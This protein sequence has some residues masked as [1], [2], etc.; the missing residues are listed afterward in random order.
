MKRKIIIPGI[1][2]LLA[3]GIFLYM[4]AN[5]G[6][7]IDVEKTSA[8]AVVTAA[9]L[10]QEYEA[11]EDKA[12]ETYASKVIQVKGAL[13]DVKSTSE[14]ELQLTLE[15]ENSIGNV[16]CNLEEN[17]E[18]ALE[19]LKIGKVVNIKG[20]CTGYMFDVVLDQSIIIN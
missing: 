15:A 20:L 7:G 12:N 3:L 18:I 14:T 4:N 17:N 16:V 1:I 8:H 6:K 2:C 9:N 13:I 10:L 19:D 11:N 5:A